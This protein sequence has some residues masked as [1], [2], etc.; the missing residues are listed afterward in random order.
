MG[1]KD[2]SIKDL[3]NYL[4]AQDFVIQTTKL[5]TKKFNTVKEFFNFI[6]GENQYWED[7]EEILQKIRNY[8]SNLILN[9][10]SLQTFL[11]DAIQ[12]AEKDFE[13]AKIKLENVISIFKDHPQTIYSDSEICHLLNQTE[14]THTV[15]GLLDFYTNN[16]I[17]THRDRAKGWLYGFLM[18]N[19]ETLL[20]TKLSTQLVKKIQEN[21]QD[22]INQ[23][24][25]KKNELTNEIN[26]FKNTISN[27]KN[28]LTTN[29]NQKV[30]TY[31]TRLKS[32]ENLY[33]E[34]LR[35]DSPA[36][37]WNSLNKIYNCRGWIFSIICLVITILIIGLSGYIIYS[38]PEAMEK[39]KSLYSA[40]NLRFSIIIAISF[41]LT[42]YMV[43]VFVRLVMS[44]FHLAE[45]AKEREQLSHFYLALIEDKNT[46]FSTQEKQII[47]QSLF[48]RSDTGLLKGD[49]H[50]NIIG[51][52]NN[53]K[54]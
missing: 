23:I 25:Q 49:G 19:Q 16:N 6:N 35:L 47:L 40:E 26:E 44:A 11:Q 37:Y 14:E 8:N 5:K 24:Y 21:I 15:S 48:S 20:P 39:T 36:K 33:Q 10:S 7:H 46:S 29:I 9:Y 22:N 34:K 17:N 13:N 18:L 43:R 2:M 27:W 54:Q 53:L 50:P 30:E 42:I 38:P 1:E 12:F 52:L 3:D 51:S 4:K 32:L 28:N 45:D 41:S 31:E